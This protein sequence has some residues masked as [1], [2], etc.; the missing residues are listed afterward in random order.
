M[1]ELAQGSTPLHQPGF[2]ILSQ[3]SKALA[4]AQLRHCTTTY[5][6]RFIIAYNGKIHRYIAAKYRVE[7]VL[8]HNDMIEQVRRRKWATGHGQETS[9]EYKMTNGNYVSQPGNITM[10]N[11]LEKTRET[12]ERRTRRLLEGQNLAQDRLI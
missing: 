4:T 12:V 5:R 10:G 3:E 11:D 9:V 8:I 7:N 6:R 1:N 2:S